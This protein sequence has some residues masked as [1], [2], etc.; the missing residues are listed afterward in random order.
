MTISWGLAGIRF[1]FST[2]IP[3]ASLLAKDLF[4]C[5]EPA[6]STPAARSCHRWSL[7][8]EGPQL[9]LSEGNCASVWREEVGVL[10]AVE[11]DAVA[12]FLDDPAAPAALHAAL[13]DIGD[14]RAVALLGRRESGK[15]T[16]ALW[17]WLKE[18]MML[19]CDDWTVLDERDGYVRPMPRRVSV[20]VTSRSV[21]GEDCWAAILQSRHQLVTTEGFLFRANCQKQRSAPVPLHSVFLLQRCN[22]Q[23]PPGVVQPVDPVDAVFAIAPYCSARNQGMGLAI[24]CAARLAESVPVFE[25]GRDTPTRMS[26]ALNKTFHALG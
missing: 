8:R 5:W 7:H 15:S 20:R 21:L 26:A 25:I 4:L 16:L 9:V 17:L 12:A 19:L 11:A 10:G 3:E 13:V 1:E 2:N 14:G 23:I 24:R 22:S 18:K 6:P